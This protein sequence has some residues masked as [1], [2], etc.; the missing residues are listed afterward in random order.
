[1]RP[2]WA[3]LSVI[4][5]VG[6]GYVSFA[7]KQT[8]DEVVLRQELVAYYADVQSAFAAGNAQRLASLYDP[9]IAKPLT[10]AEVEAWATKFFAE[11]GRASFHVKKMEIE[12][13]GFQDAVVI[14]DYAVET[15][16]G[17]GGFT[18]LERDS[19][20]KH[21]AHWSVKGWEKL[22]RK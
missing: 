16:S 18:G 9:A 10:R 5:F 19:L 4:F 11:H 12:Q 21:G 20:S 13:M 15:P 8:T 17:K 14:L 1:M 7:R 22:V 6:C 3:F 2:R